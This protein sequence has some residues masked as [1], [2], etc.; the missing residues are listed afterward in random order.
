MK[1]LINLLI[2]FFKKLFNTNNYLKSEDG[3]F[4]LSEDG[5]FIKLNK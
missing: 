5:K 4:L 2:I 1:K 3:E